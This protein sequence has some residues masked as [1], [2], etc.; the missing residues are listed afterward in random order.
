MPRTDTP[1]PFHI[2]N[3]FP[4]IDTMHLSLDIPYVA[5]QLHAGLRVVDN[6]RTVRRNENRTGSDAVIPSHSL[7]A[8]NIYQKPY[9]SIR[10]STHSHATFPP[11]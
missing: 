3:N 5:F 10:Y 2:Q 9:K 8:F 11:R 6:S 4:R 7:R 1:N